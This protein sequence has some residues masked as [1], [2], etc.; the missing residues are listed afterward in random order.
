MNACAARYVYTVCLHP[1]YRVLACDECM[2]LCM[3]VALRVQQLWPMPTTS[4]ISSS[5]CA[6]R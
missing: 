2:W 3:S 5:W 4:M 1:A 6:S